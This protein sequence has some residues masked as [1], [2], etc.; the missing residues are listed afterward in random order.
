MQKD[1]GGD[2]KLQARSLQKPSHILP[3]QTDQG[4]MSMIFLIIK[5]NEFKK[6]N[7]ALSV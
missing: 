6:I 1:L 5:I 2:H 3:E 7:R 4:L